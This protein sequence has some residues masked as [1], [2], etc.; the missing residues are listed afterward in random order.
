MTRLAL[1]WPFRG[2]IEGL[3]K[4]SSESTD[5]FAGWLPDSTNAVVILGL[6]FFVLIFLYGLCDFLERLWFARFAIGTMRDL[7]LEAFRAAVINHEKYSK[8][9]RG[10]LIARLIGDTARIKNGLKG[11]FVHFLPNLFLFLGVTIILLLM[12]LHLGLIFVTSFLAVGTITVFSSFRQFKKSLKHR[13]KEGELSNQMLETFRRID[14]DRNRE[15]FNRTFE[16]LNKKSGLYEASLTRAE[17][18]T[19]WAICV[20]FGLTVLLAIWIGTDA[21]KQDQ[22]NMGDMVVFMMYAIMLRGPVMRLGRYGTRMGKILGTSYRVAKILPDKNEKNSKADSAPLDP[23]GLTDYL[24]QP[25]SVSDD[26]L[27]EDQNE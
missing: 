18:L 6:V 12:N 26:I 13:K 16:K 22:L 4:A 20:I 21:V 15:E 27:L 1:P 11:F 14:K 9:K 17:G 3:F 5:I 7:R 10:D 25:E 23:D 24:A 8:K 2:I 19:T